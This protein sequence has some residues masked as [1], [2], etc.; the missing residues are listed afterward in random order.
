MPAPRDG[1]AKARGQ[2][3]KG[4][5]R[6]ELGH[7][8]VCQCRPRLR[9][10]VL[11]GAPA[12]RVLVMAGGDDAVLW[13]RA[14]RS[15]VHVTETIEQTVGG[16]PQSPS[17]RLR[18]HFPAAP[19]KLT[20]R[21]AG[22]GQAAARHASAMSN[23]CVYKYS[24]L[25]GPA[26]PARPRRD[27]IRCPSSSSS[28]SRVFNKGQMPGHRRTD[29]AVAAAAANTPPLTPAGTSDP[30]QAKSPSS[31]LPPRGGATFDPPVRVPGGGTCC[32]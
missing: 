17:V 32:R 23:R 14:E 15:S 3:G 19:Q 26:R 6:Q 1:G 22:T 9:R 31:P 27:D 5:R 20:S 28:S 30:L 25:R 13:R 18:V 2:G 7:F 24:A 16:D 10:C 11:C 12:G 4:A 29:S 21:R 8:G